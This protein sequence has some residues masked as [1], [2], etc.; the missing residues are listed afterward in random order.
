MEHTCK[1]CGKVFETLIALIHHLLR[2]E[3]KA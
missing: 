1:N 2:C 3:D